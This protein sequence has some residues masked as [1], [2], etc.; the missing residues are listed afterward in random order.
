MPVTNS[1]NIERQATA[2]IAKLTQCRVVSLAADIARPVSLGQ[3]DAGSIKRAATAAFCDNAEAMGTPEKLRE[4]IAQTVRRFA[5]SGLAFRVAKG[6]RM[7]RNIHSD[8][9]ATEAVSTKKELIK[10][11]QTRIELIERKRRRSPGGGSSSESLQRRG[12]P[13]SE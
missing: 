7:K 8:N 10:K 12:G 6:N 11:G 4:D 1:E 9:L 13:V 2:A 3:I 5:L